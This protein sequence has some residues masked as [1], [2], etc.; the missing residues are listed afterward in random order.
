[1]EFKN[2]LYGKWA[3]LSS[4]VGFSQYVIGMYGQPYAPNLVRI[5]QVVPEI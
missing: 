1:M 5:G 3:G 4:E 2:L